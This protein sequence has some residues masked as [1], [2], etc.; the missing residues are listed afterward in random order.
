MSDNLSVLLNITT[1]K[2]EIRLIYFYHY[3]V[4]W[5]VPVILLFGCSGTSICIVVLVKT[6]KRRAK[7]WSWFLVLSTND[8][9]S[10]I[11]GLT[12]L[13]LNK[14]Y[15]ITNRASSISEDFRSSNIFVCHFLSTGLYFTLF[16]SSWM[17]V[18]ISVIRTISISCPLFIKTRFTASVARKALVIHISITLLFSIILVNSTLIYDEVYSGNFSRGF[19]CKLSNKYDDLFYFVSLVF[20][21]II[22]T[23]ILIL[24]SII[25]WRNL[26]SQYDSRDF[27]NTD[28]IKFTNSDT[29]QH[30]EHSRRIS[31]NRNLSLTL[32]GMNLTFLLSNL[33]F[34][35]FK[36]INR[37]FNINKI[38]LPKDF[39]DFLTMRI[40]DKSFNISVYFNQATNWMFYFLLGKSFRTFFCKVIYCRNRTRFQRQYSLKNVRFK[41][42]SEYLLVT[43]D[44]RPLKLNSFKLDHRCDTI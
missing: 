43:S 41:P 20:K 33:P 12:S 10:L 35:I 7:I 11:L 44:S 19:R 30:S 13:Y 9:I 3:V 6:A 28:S 39:E 4:S 5:L 36:V 14:L 22:P 21:V 37:N 25:I 17:Q 32:L 8:I 2:Y 29:P 15:L 26:S 16:L 27:N 38:K 1:T 24:S 42:S 34:E 31:I 18:G 40:L 23:L